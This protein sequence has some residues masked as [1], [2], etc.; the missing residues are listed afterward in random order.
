VGQPDFAEHVGQ[1]APLVQRRDNG[2]VR[3]VSYR[4]QAH[5]EGAG[6]RQGI[7]PIA[8][9]AATENGDKSL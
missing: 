9:V 6:D 7:A 5:R 2:V 8:P 3:H 1:A 4:I